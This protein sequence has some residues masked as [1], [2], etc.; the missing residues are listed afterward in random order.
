MKLHNISKKR[1]NKILETVHDS[2]V[3]LHRAGLIDAKTMAE[4]DALCLPPVKQY[5]ALQIKKLRKRFNISQ[6]VLAAYLNTSP[7]TV[8]QWEQGVRKPNSIAMK[9]LDLVDHLG[10]QI[11]VYES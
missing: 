2:A 4:F 9:L 5:T 8:K 7:N 6:P 11:L 3:G 10:L 1:P